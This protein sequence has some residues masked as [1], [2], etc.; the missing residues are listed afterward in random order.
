METRMPSE[1]STHKHNLPASVSSF[2]GR[3]QELREIRQRLCEHRLIMLTATG[4]TGKTR[5]A[6]EAVA[7]VVDDFADGVWLVE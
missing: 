2:I 3:E 4:G 1:G 7:G 5:L 6:I